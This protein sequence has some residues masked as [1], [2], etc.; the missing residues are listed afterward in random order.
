MTAV[1]FCKEAATFRYYEYCFL[2]IENELTLV[3]VRG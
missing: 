2:M 1:S 3:Y